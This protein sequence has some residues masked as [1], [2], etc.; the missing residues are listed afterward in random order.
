MFR[1][2]L[3]VTIAV[4]LSCGAARAEGK[5]VALV[6]G[7][8]AYRY[9]GGLAN[10][11]ND[12]TDVASALKRLGFQVAHRN[13]LERQAF[14]RS[15]DAFYE[16]SRG[17]DLAIFFYAG[18][19][20]QLDGGAYILPTDARL[21]GEFA[22]K[23]ETLSAQD[24]VERIGAAS[25]ASIVLLDACRNNP[26]V[27]RLRGEASAGG[28]AANVGRGFARVERGLGRI[29][30]GGNTLVVY[31]A[32][33][34]QE[35]RDGAGRN[36]PFTEALLKHIETP[37]LEVE[38]MFKRVTAA[39]DQS[40]GGGQLPERLSQ[41]KIEV[42]LRPAPASAL[43]PPPDDEA[44]KKWEADL[45]K[46]EEAIRKRATAIENGQR[47]LNKKAEELKK[48]KAELEKSK[49]VAQPDHASKPI[50]GYASA[51]EPSSN[52]AARSDAPAASGAAPRPLATPLP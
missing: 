5:R 20:L 45:R 32:K 35:A 17:A 26:L 48:A 46:Q 9:A 51:P 1:R 25:R 3:G 13:N 52:P 39:V 27:E 38:Q 50:N 2:V 18:H 24:I 19:G 4:L 29:E 10:P 47:E 43:L 22:V 16:A 28:R 11:V 8:S 30:V 14:G 31:S 33:P 21:E 40:T 7:N 49:K 12:A 44:R 23:Q 34:G 36:S 6:I 41:L 37:G 42:T 15:L